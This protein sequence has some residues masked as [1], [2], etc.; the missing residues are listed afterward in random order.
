MFDIPDRGAYFKLPL[1]HLHSLLYTPLDPSFLKMDAE[2]TA[3]MVDWVIDNIYSDIDL[4]EAPYY[5]LLKL[6]LDTYKFTMGGEKA[7]KN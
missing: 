3:L 1:T 7:I 2:K 5:E 4:D 6:A